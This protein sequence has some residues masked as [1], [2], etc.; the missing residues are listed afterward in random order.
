M[1]RRR[2][3]SRPPRTALLAALSLL[4]LAA[5]SE[6]DS[7]S[8]PG[9]DLPPVTDSSGALPTLRNEPGDFTLDAHRTELE[10]VVPPSGTWVLRDRATG[11]LLTADGWAFD[12]PLAEAGVRLP[13]LAKTSAFW[14]AWSVFHPGSEIWGRDTDVRD[15]VIRSDEDCLVPCDQIRRNLPRDAIPSLPNTG[16]PQGA[17]RFTDAGSSDAAYLQPHDM[18]I[19]LFDGTEARAYPH[20]VLWWHE[21]VNDTFGGQPL[22]VSFCPLTGSAL[23]FSAQQSAFGVSGNLYNS[24]LVLY[25]HDTASLFSQMRREAVTGA[26]KGEVIEEIPFVETTWERWEQMHPGT[27]VI[28][29]STGFSRDYTRYPYGDYRSDDRDTFAVTDPAPDAQFPG[30]ALVTGVHAGGTSKV[31]VHSV[32][33]QSMGNRAVFRDEVGGLPVWVLYDST[34]TFLQIVHAG[35][36]EFELDLEWTRLP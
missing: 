16:P 28:A 18:V 27:R 20:N 15:A 29:S 31:Y 10:V 19:G 5:C 33:R 35:D 21:I 4:F 34:A 22:S 26:R 12:G 23:V 7:P 6:T 9:V 36:P 17:P 25:D 8:D 3:R 14:F 32:V 1:F 11:S 2:F 13:H 30:K 24:N